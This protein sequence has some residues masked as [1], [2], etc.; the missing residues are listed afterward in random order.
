MV[1]SNGLRTTGEECFYR[2]EVTASKRHMGSSA[3]VRIGI[4]GWR[5]KGWRG[6]F[7][8]SGLAQR[9][10]LEFAS[11]R[12]N[13]IELNGSFYSLQRPQSFQRWH[14]ETPQDFV[15][16]VKGTRF[17]TH[18]L[19]LRQVETPLANFFAQGVLRLKEKLGPILWQFPANFKW[20]PDRLDAFFSI[21][22]RSHKE[23]ARLAKRHDQRLDGRSWFAVREDRPLR[24]AIEI[25]NDTFVREEFI[26]LLRKHK[27]ALV[28]AD[29]VEWP[30]LMDVTAD[31]VYCR[32]HGSEVLYASGYDQDSIDRWANRVVLWTQGREVED[33]RKAS[34]INGPAAQFRDVY[35]YFDNDAKVRAP[36]DAM[37]LQKRIS[38]LQ[39]RSIVDRNGPSELKTDN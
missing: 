21:L 13:S 37:E 4:S 12:L 10:E 32:L 36:V 16:S 7:Y 9:R 5:Y 8:P 3:K 26:A 38:E 24:H 23:A 6:T 34:A 18:M 17:I 22:P 39:D 20:E 2:P 11:Q 29:T 33:G 30:L 27:V 1:D 35:I 15:F 28:V 14:E 31:F 25:R 19:R